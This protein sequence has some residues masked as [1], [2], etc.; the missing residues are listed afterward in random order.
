MIGILYNR[1]FDLNPLSGY[2][3]ILDR[4]AAGCCVAGR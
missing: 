1:V 2:G 4:V 3:G